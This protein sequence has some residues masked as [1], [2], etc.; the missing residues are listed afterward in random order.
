MIKP[1]SVIRSEV[2]FVRNWPLCSRCSRLEWFGKL[3]GF[4]WFQLVWVSYTLEISKVGNYKV[5]NYKVYPVKDR[6]KF[7][8][9]KLQER[10]E[11][12]F[13]FA[14]RCIPQC[15]LN[16]TAKPKPECTSG[17]FESSRK[18]TWI[19][20]RTII[21]WTKRLI[22]EWSSW[23]GLYYSMNISDVT[24]LYWSALALRDSPAFRWP[25]SNLPNSKN[26]FNFWVYSYLNCFD[27]ST[28]TKNLLYEEQSL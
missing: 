15:L 3:Q 19:Q 13:R 22:M 11:T 9:L 24:F 1:K 26:N 12:L 16:A 10:L 23:Y 6:S 4:S 21:R 27:Q 2:K 25:N 7:I 14:T 5:D 20:T 28:K 17:H 18:L 8:S